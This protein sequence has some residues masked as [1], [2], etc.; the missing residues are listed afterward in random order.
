[1]HKVVIMDQDGNA[2]L[3]NLTNDEHQELAD[4]DN[5]EFD[6]LANKKP[7]TLP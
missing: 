7:I 4:L 6:K 1:M 2:V 3:L 5:A